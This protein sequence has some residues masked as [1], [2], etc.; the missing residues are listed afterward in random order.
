MAE[1]SFENPSDDELRK[2]YDD[3]ATIAVVGA[4]E[5]PGKPAFAIPRQLQSLGYRIV[6]VNPK[7][8][9]ILGERA[10]RSLDE[11]D[12]PIDVVDVFRPAEE[13]PDIARQAVRAGAK[14]LWLQEGIVSEEAA[15]IA[16]AGGLTAVMGICM[17]H[18][19]RRLG[20]SP[21]PSKG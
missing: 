7:G 8:G 6:P 14:V 15:S 9:E 21:R 2:I 19:A 4:S 5:N 1:A 17:G 12:V 18:T 16:R 10:Y 13:T 20:I 11:V 3:V